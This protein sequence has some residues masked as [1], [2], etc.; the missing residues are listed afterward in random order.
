MIPVRWLGFS[1]V[2]IFCGWWQ[3]QRVKIYR[4]LWIKTRL[5]GTLGF[6]PGLVFVFAKFLKKYW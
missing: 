1:P 2:A 6:D 4:I 3:W 5:V